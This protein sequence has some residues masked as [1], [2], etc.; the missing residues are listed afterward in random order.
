MTRVWGTD[1]DDRQHETQH[2]TVK[3]HTI[4]TNQEQ[5]IK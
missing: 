5:H 1:T 3:H 4:T 2:N